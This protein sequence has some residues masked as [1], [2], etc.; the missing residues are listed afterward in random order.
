MRRKRQHQEQNGEYANR[1]IDSTRNSIFHFKSPKQK[2]KNQKISIE[3]T[4][5]VRLLIRDDAKGENG[6]IWIFGGRMKDRKKRWLHFASQWRQRSALAH[7]TNFG[8]YYL[9]LSNWEN[10]ARRGRERERWNQTQIDYY[11]ICDCCVWWEKLKLNDRGVWI[12][13]WSCVYWNRRR[14]RRYWTSDIKNKYA[15]L[16]RVQFGSVRFEEIWLSIS[17]RMM[18]HG[19]HPDYSNIKVLDTSHMCRYP[20]HSQLT[21]I[22]LFISFHSPFLFSSSPSFHLLDIFSHRW[23]SILK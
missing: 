20:S 8:S 14:H 19:I 23:D 18:I 9:L 13:C 3:Q 1:R 12:V 6:W 5:D 21:F 10:Y 17:V 15:I 22:L 2:H 4:Y 16:R 11:I 7:D